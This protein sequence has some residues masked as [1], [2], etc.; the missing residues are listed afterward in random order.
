MIQSIFSYITRSTL[1][2]TRRVPALDFAFVQLYPRPPSLHVAER[3]PLCIDTL[4]M[5]RLPLV[6]Q[7]LSLAG[8][9][10]RPLDASF[11]F[12]PLSSTAR[13]S[14]GFPFAITVPSHISVLLHAWRKR[15][16]V[17]KKV[18]VR[19]SKAQEAFSRPRRVVPTIRTSPFLP[20]SNF[21][22][23]V[24]SFASLG[25]VF[26]IL[27]AFSLRRSEPEINLFKQRGG[28]RN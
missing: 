7:A 5:S 11:P 25:K 15:I 12:R 24:R 19:L 21:R 9:S 27:K 10:M 4:K 18:F 20:L 8:A 17:L 14:L 13:R 1:L 2:S 3:S 28:R 22:L 26:S 23:K 6:S 16:E